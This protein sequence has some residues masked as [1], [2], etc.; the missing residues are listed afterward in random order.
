MYRLVGSGFAEAS[1]NHRLR[2]EAIFPAALS[3]IK[4]AVRFLRANAAQYGLAPERFAIWGRISRRLP[5]HHDRRH[6]G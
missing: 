4:A 3:D 6:R 2:G 5:R 1:V